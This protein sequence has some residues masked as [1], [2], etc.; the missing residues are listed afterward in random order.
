MNHSIQK[1]LYQPN[2]LEKLYRKD[3]IQFKNSFN[4]LYPTLEHTEI[5]EVWNER[6]NFKDETI[7]DFSRKEFMVAILIALLSGVSSRLV[8]YF[9]QENFLNPINFV[10]VSMGFISI[11]FI[12]KNHLSKKSIMLIFIPLILVLMS[13]NSIQNTS[14]DVS[15]LVYLHVPILMWILIGISYLADEVKNNQKRLAFLRFN[16]EFI[17]LYTIMAISGILLTGI[18]MQLFYMIN[19]DIS[20]FYFTNIVLF[21]VA[22][23][24]ILTIYLIDLNLNIVR[25]IAP[26]IAKLFGPLVLITLFVFI[27]TVILTGQN[28][29]IDR[30]FLFVFNIILLIVLAISVFSIIES[31]DR[32][33]TN[34][35]NLALIS[36]ALLIDLFAL[37]AILFRLGSFGLTPNRCAVLGI[38]LI[39]GF[40]LS[41]ILF[42]YIKY[43]RTKKEIGI[44]H[45]AITDYLPLYGIW[46]LI[47]IFV[48]PLLF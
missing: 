1:Y 30:E 20:E 9:V 31:S 32:R 3:S 4:E 42:S 7:T 14:S 45:K 22:S 38:N 15:I 34:L 46:S 18:T 11:Y 26:L 2:E 40:H 36:I 16:G 48:F 12:I 37:S 41:N 33:F 35:I 24:S 13:V 47:V 44:I 10:F 27:L 17:V 19:L 23:V 5:V 29:F 25:N 43:Y 6:L 39:I 8:F 28:P 21:G